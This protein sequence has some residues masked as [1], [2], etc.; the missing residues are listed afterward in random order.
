[1]IS[2]AETLE[3]VSDQAAVEEIRQTAVKQLRMITVGVADW[4]SDP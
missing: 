3:D 1:M 4:Q 2:I